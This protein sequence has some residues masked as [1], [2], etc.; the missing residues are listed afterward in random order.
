MLCKYPVPYGMAATTRIMSYAKGLLESGEDV[1]VWSCIPTG[2]FGGCSESK[3]TLD[4]V[5]FIYTYKRNRSKLKII[6]VFEHL[7]SYIIL[8]LKFLSEHKSKKIDVVILS[9]DSIFLQILVGLLCKLKDI[10]SI[11]IFDEFPYPIRVK[12][13]SRLP[14][15]KKIAYFISLRL[16]HGYISMTQTLLDFYQGLVNK[17][18]IV[19]ST[20]TDLTRFKSHDIQKKKYNEPFSLVYMGNMELSK[21]NVDNIIRAIPDVINEF[22]VHLSLYGRPSHADLN[23]LSNLISDLGIADYVSF[24]YAKPHEV[25]YVLSQADLLVSSQP[26]TKRAMGGFPTKLGEYLMSGVPVL[27]TDVGETSKYF[28]DGEDMFF[29]K[30]ESPSDFARLIKFIRINYEFALGVANNGKQK[31]ITTYSHTKAGSDIK[32]F[33]N[34][35]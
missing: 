31:I 12:L 3:G 14:Y 35:L 18:G 2:E 13:K 5:N 8:P 23:K 32:E 33:I 1:E 24:N 4:G 7:I 34:N 15:L 17:P 29:A 16:F 6:R 28:I 25:A 10:K 27:L 22:S 30:P 9:S 11:F 26:D 19:V 21:D 20:I